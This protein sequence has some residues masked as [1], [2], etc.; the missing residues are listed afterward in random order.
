[1]KALIND[2]ISKFTDDWKNE[3]SDFKIIMK[4]GRL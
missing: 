4:K 1:L 3:A 2:E